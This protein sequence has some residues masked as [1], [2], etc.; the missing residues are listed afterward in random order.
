MSCPLVAGA[1]AT[2]LEADPTLKFADVLDII[3]T[4][5]IR[6][7][8]VREGNAAQW[9][10]GK[11]DAYA[12]LKEVL[13]RRNLAGIQ[14]ISSPSGDK[15]GAA[16]NLQGQRVSDSYKGVIIKNGKKVLR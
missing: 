13:R 3:Q 10:A 1:I 14:N 2:W 16:Y 5:A 9:G 7:E 4:T 11:F 6:D 15:R 12:G 8:Y